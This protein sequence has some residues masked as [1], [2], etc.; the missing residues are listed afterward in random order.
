MSSYSFS[1]TDDDGKTWT[2]DI[3]ESGDTW[4]EMLNDFVKFME[5]IYDYPIKPK[6]RLKAPIWIEFMDSSYHEY[7]PWENNYWY[8]DE[9]EEDNE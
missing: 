6:I 8:P 5:S 9:S 4:S 7:D 2:L 3:Q 1:Y